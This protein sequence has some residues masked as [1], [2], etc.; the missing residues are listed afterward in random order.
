M[1]QP[2]H[3]T[4]DNVVRL[5]REGGLAHFPGLARPRCID[6]ARCSEAQRDELWRLLSYAEAN[7]GQGGAPGADRRRFCLR[8]EDAS[9]ASIWNVTVAE[10]VVPPGLLEWWRR[11]DIQAENGSGP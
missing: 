1:S 5:Q 11:A 7:A 4:R 10:E 6:C 3:L 8:V 9:G 2:P